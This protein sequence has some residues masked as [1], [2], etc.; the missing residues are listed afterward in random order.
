MNENPFDRFDLDPLASPDEITEV[1]RERIEDAPAAERQALRDAWENLTLHP[2][3]RL[4][5]ALSTFVDPEPAPPVL[6]PP[7]A[8][9]APEHAVRPVDRA[10]LAVVSDLHAALEL[11]GL[12][13]HEPTGYVSI[14]SDPLLKDNRP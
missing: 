10:T 13:T 11:E 7:P 5:L 3:K 14:A 12:S 8:R 6:R 1:L 2:R 9:A 4:A